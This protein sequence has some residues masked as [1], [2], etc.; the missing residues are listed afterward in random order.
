MAKFKENFES[1]EPMPLPLKKKRVST[2]N[3][4]SLLCNDDNDVD[5]LEKG[6][7]NKKVEIESEINSYFTMRIKVNEHSYL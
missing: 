5:T 1:A 3:N 4:L 2:E 6:T 7:L